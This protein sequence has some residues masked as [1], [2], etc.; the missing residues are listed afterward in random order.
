MAIVESI[1]NRCLLC[2]KE[3][4]RGGFS[5]QVSGVYL[6]PVCADCQD[7]CSSDPNGVVTEHPQLFEGTEIVNPHIHPTSSGTQFRPPI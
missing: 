7:R 4:P 5:A 6:F 1:T 3:L 2:G